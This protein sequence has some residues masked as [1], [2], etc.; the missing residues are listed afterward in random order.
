MS[1][2]HQDFLWKVHDYIS[3]NIKFADTKAALSFAFSSGILSWITSKHHRY[4]DPQRF[5]GFTTFLLWTGVAFLLAGIFV[6]VWALIPRLWGKTHK[7]LI[8][9]EQVALFENGEAYEAAI[10]KTSERGFDNALADH[11]HIMARLASRKFALIGNGVALAAAGALLV[12]YPA[13][14][15]VLT[16]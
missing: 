9:W 6:F 12:A 16:D 3:R 14:K 10:A 15:I 5:G 2:T 13:I 1:N 11:V 7:G 8:F 4:A